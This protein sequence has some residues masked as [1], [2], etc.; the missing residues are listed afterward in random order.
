MHHVLEYKYWEFADKFVCFTWLLIMFFFINTLLWKQ[1]LDTF[2]QNVNKVW[3]IDMFYLYLYLCTEQIYD[4]LLIIWVM[5]VS[6]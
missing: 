6:L 3:Y 4:L 1:K 2:N 5:G